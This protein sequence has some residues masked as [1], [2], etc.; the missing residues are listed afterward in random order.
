M[1]DLRQQAITTARGAKR[2]G[3]ILGTLGRQGNP[4]I[5]LRLEALLGRHGRSCFVLLLSEITPPKLA[6]FSES[7]DAWIQVRVMPSEESEARAR[8]AS[9]RR[10]RETRTRDASG[11]RLL[12]GA[13]GRSS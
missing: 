10:K 2:F 6:L 1:L 8:R 5:V 9:E 4:S 11:A 12:G 3:L 13:G 7:V